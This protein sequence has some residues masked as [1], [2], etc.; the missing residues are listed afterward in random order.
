IVFAYLAAREAVPDKPLVAVTAAGF[1]AFIPQ[2]IAM[3]AGI[4]NDSLSELLIAVGLWLTLRIHSRRSEIS[5]WRFGILE[6]GLLGFVI[7]LA[8]ITK[9]QAYVLAPVAGVM[10]LF[11]WRRDGWGERR[12]FVQ[13]AAI[14]FVPALIVGSLFWAR[15]VAVYGWPDFMASIRHDQVVADQPRTKQWIEEFGTTEVLR[16]FGQTTFQSFWGQFGWMGVVMDRRVYWAL[17]A[18]SV[19]LVVGLGIGGWRLVASGQRP[20]A[21]SHQLGAIVL[22][23][24]SA[25]LTLGLYL[26]YNLTYVQHQGRYLF[27]A[28]IPI[29]LGASVSL[30]AWAAVAEVLIKR[31]IG[32]LVPLGALVCMAALDVFALYRFILPALPS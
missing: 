4:N 10:L 27:P 11:K 25:L 16:R 30:W 24:V 23:T 31:K 7:G 20:A 1:I 28:L 26:Y 12:M 5:D 22:L 9:S 3:M 19:G 32:W 8:F 17:G 21:N 15:N 6:F 14:V 18:Y 13:R 29:G 2:H